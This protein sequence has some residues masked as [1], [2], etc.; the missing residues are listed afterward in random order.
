MQDETIGKKAIFIDKCKGTIV[1]YI[2]E[3]ESGI[4]HT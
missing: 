1:D 2:K 3:M 4:W